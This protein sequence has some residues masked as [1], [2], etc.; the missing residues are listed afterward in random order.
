MKDQLFKKPKPSSYK[1]TFDE[2]VAEVFDDMLLRS[3]PF[4]EEIVRM[5]G[6][7]ASTYYQSNSKVY[8]LGCSTGIILCHLAQLLS[9]NPPQLIGVDSSKAMIRKAKSRISRLPMPVSTNIKLQ[10]ED[11]LHTSITNASIIIMNFTLQ[12]IPP[13]QRQFFLDRI[14]QQL[15][16]QGVLLIS[17]KVKHPHQ[18]I[19]KQELVYYEGFK[20]R[21]GYSETEIS[22]K[23]KALEDVLIAHTLQENLNSLQQAGF[24]RTDVIFKWYNFASF[25]AIKH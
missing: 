7:I 20:K 9:P 25:L 2:S 5:T 14:Y 12:F 10:C 3:I 13:K 18:E 16:P 8:D 6:E 19:E 24:E 22:Q 4:Y 21:N 11:I 17:E 1:F 23:R 15:Q